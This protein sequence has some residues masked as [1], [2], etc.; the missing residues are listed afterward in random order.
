MLMP[1]LKTLLPFVTFLILIQGLAAWKA[2]S[3]S[4]ADNYLSL[5]DSCVVNRIGSGLLGGADTRLTF[6][7]SGEIIGLFVT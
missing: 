6:V 2:N 3:L 4:F 1:F 7:M 5:A